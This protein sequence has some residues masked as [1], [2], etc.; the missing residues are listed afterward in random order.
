MED[1]QHD[2]EE[3]ATPIAGIRANILENGNVVVAW[4]CQH[5]LSACI[6]DFHLLMRLTFVLALFIFGLGIDLH[7]FLVNIGVIRW[8]AS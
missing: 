3:E 6:F 8:Q 2:G 5:L 4:L 7:V 1:K